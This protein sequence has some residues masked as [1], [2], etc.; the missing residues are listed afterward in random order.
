MCLTAIT[1]LCKFNWFRPQTAAR[2]P[3]Q[4][5]DKSRIGIVGGLAYTLKLRATHTY[6][7]I[8]L[9]I[10]VHVYVCVYALAL[11]YSSIYVFN[12]NADCLLFASLFCIWLLLYNRWSRCS[13]CSL[14]FPLHQR[15]ISKNYQS[16]RVLLYFQ[17]VSL[18]HRGALCNISQIIATNR[19]EL[20]E[21]NVMTLYG[22]IEMNCQASCNYKT[23]T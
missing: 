3:G 4:T 23:R 6:T 12:F 5:T 7:N 9:C 1:G 2:S 19:K 20:I 16:F 14:L 18:M 22:I 10:Y 13:C 21:Y 15:I 17:F 8:F 11:I